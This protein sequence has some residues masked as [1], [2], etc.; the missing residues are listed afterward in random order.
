MP[1][2][3]EV[4]ST[5]SVIPAELTVPDTG[6]FAVVVAPFAGIVFVGPASVSAPMTVDPLATVNVIVPTAPAPGLIGSN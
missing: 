3:G 6:T 4:T 5:W 1:P 2:C